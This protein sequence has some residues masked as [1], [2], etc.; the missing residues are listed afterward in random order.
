MEIVCRGL[1]FFIDISIV[2]ANKIY[3]LGIE[4]E[5]ADVFSNNNNCIV[6]E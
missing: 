3:N 1:N 6:I 2:S 4:I 5:C